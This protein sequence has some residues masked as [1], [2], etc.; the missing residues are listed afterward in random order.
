MKSVFLMQNYFF[1]VVEITGC[2]LILYKNAGL[3]GGQA[4]YR[5]RVLSV[6]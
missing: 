5:V 1:N 6:R 4:F 3:G 2:V